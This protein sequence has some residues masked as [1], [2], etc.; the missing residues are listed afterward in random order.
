MN[1]LLNISKLPIAILAVISLASCSNTPTES[2]AA[3]TQ[4]VNPEDSKQRAL[5]TILS[6]LP[7]ANP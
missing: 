7:R 5:S 3:D 6:D 4:I 2:S 1:I